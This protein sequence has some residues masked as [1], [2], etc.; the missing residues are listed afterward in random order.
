MVLV[1]LLLI[2]SLYGDKVDG[3]TPLHNSVFYE[4]EA[5]TRSLI[6][7]GADV[8]AENAAGL[9]P[10]HI[11]IKKRDLKMAQIL[12][13]NGANIDAQDNRGNTVLILAIKKHN[14][15]LVRFVV[16]N[17]ADTARKRCRY[18]RPGQQGQHRADPGDQEA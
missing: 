9:T 1:L 14:I 5:L 17:G 4:D 12:L 2:A 11:A 13:E 8:N 3:R 16:V 15:K 18:R 6:K 7:E 10:L